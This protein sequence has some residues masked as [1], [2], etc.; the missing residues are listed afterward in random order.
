[1]TSRCFAVIFLDCNPSPPE[2]PPDSP[3]ANCITINEMNE[4]PKSIGMVNSRR[5][6]M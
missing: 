3:G 5:L 6:R 2:P 4:M 1:M